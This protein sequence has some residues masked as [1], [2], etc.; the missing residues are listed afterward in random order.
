MHWKKESFSRNSGSKP[1]FPYTEK[2]D[3]ISIAHFVQKQKNNNKD[4]HQVKMSERH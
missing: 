1:V 2:C 4:T 3:F